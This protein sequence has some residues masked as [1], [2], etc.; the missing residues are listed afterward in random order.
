MSNIKSRLTDNLIAL[1]SIGEQIQQAVGR[2][3]NHEANGNKIDDPTMIECY[4]LLLVL[5]RDQN[6]VS[7]I[8]T[9]ELI[10]LD[11]RT[12]GQ[13]NTINTL[14]TH[15]NNHIINA[16]KKL[17]TNSDATLYEIIKTTIHNIFNT[18]MP[19]WS[20]L[21]IFLVCCLGIYIIQNGLPWI[22]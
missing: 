4:S 13:Q 18:A 20:I 10:G 12:E 19:I 6:K 15:A 5:L 14:I 11:A 21:V 1:N 16:D 2:V 9:Q 8:L 17:I 7:G 22:N 3:Q